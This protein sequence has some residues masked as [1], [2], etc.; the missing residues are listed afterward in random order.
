MGTHPIFESDFD[1]L[2]E[3]SR[4]SEVD[5]VEQIWKLK[6]DLQHVEKLGA[7]V[8]ALKNHLL[9]LSQQKDLARQG[10]R[11]LQKRTDQKPVFLNL[12]TFIQFDPAEA[13][14]LMRKEMLELDKEINIQRDLLKK[15]AAACDKAIGQN[16]MEG[17][18]L[19][20]VS[21]K[22]IREILQ[23]TDPSKV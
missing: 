7:D 2:T 18:H 4:M 12:G 13:E 8:I 3:I 11:A 1:C 15:A 17:M 6:S 9:G 5:Q 20:P 16:K 10:W 22:E 23:K 14:N 19:N 21:S